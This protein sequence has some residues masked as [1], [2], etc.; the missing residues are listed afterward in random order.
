MDAE[1]TFRFIF[2]CSNFRCLPRGD[3]RLLATHSWYTSLV[4]PVLHYCSPVWSPHLRKD[5]ATFEKVQRRTRR[6][7]IRNTGRDMSYEER[8]KVLK[9]P[10]LHQ[11]RLFSSLTECYK[12]ANSLNELHLFEYFTF[13]HDFRPLR[14]N[15]RHKLK[16][17]P[18]KLNSFKYSFCANIVNEWN[19]LPKK[20]AKA[21]TLNIFKNRLRCHFTNVL[22][23]F[24]LFYCDF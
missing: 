23:N 14:T 4:H 18:A 21:K 20:V 17:L 22:G 13:A 6:Y 19:N 7:A 2:L 1:T 15:H 3:P 5:S 8:L 9:W 11:R 10:T 12:T 24:E 16:P